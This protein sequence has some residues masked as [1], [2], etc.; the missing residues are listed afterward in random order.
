[1]IQPA[2][3]FG[4][5]PATSRTLLLTQAVYSSRARPARPGRG[6]PVCST[7]STR[8]PTAVCASVYHARAGVPFQLPARFD[9]PLT[10]DSR[11]EPGAQIASARSASPCK[12]GLGKHFHTTALPVWPR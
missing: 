1:M 6:R 7:V 2:G 10:R 3:R 12:R 9:A 4:P 8:S 5:T 11:V